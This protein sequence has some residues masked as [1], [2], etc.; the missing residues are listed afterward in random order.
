MQLL[1]NERL[2]TEKV[3]E[4]ERIRSGKEI[5]ALHLEEQIK[6]IRKTQ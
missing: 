2:I 1:E 3:M 6:Q 5:G 4:T